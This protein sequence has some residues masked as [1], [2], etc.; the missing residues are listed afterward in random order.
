[1]EFLF[2]SIC[3]LLYNSKITTV[4]ANLGPRR[5]STTSIGGPCKCAAFFP[6]LPR[7]THH[8]LWMCDDGEWQCSWRTYGHSTG[9]IATLVKQNKLTYEFRVE[10]AHAWMH[11]YMSVI[12]PSMCCACSVGAPTC[13]LLLMT[14]TLSCIPSDIATW[15]D[16]VLERDVHNLICG[17][18]WRHTC[19]PCK[20]SIHQE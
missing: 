11:G 20:G 14:S 2:F 12:S 1:M 19:F 3:S 9:P 4:P 15:K 16:D 10:T 13:C 6:D 8:G 18:S 5:R 7:S 17:H